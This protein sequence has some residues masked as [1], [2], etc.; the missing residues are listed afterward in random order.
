MP[1]G[2]GLAGQVGWAQEVYTNEV[3]TLTG[4]PSV[5]FTLTFDG[6]TTTV[7]ATNAAAATIQNAL[8]ALPNIGA[9]G[10][11]CSGG[12]LPAAVTITFSGPQ[13][14]GRNIPALT[15]NLA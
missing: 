13:V 1:V 11:A 15:V 7:L 5:P 14:A 2:A 10:V 8:N 6:A 4:T 12:A 3:Q 9:G